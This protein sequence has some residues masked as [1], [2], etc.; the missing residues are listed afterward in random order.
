MRIYLEGGPFDGK[1]V[2][3]DCAN[4]PS[5]VIDHEGRLDTLVMP[6]D[7]S[8]HDRMHP[9]G[10]WLCD[11]DKL[12]AEGA[13]FAYDWTD[14]TLDDGTPVLEFEGKNRWKQ[15][16]AKRNRPRAEPA[17]SPRRSSRR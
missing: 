15:M 4:V 1:V 11:P 3:L 12:Q 7:P 14:R 2:E 5:I 10:T 8:G 17:G 16:I 6:G 13:F 9:V